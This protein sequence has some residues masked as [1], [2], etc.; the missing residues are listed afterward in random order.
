MN[1]L[2][3]I[4]FWCSYENFRRGIARGK[5]SSFLTLSCEILLQR[6]WPAVFLSVSEGPIASFQYLL[7]SKMVNQIIFYCYFSF[8]LWLLGK[9]NIFIVFVCFFCKFPIYFCPPWYLFIWFFL[10]LFIYFL[11]LIINRVKLPFL[12]RGVCSSEF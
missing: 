1:F 5:S 7:W 10:N 2:R 11:I 8:I 4:L 3:N 9:V 12:K 6:N